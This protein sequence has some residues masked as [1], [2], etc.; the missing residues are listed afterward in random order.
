MRHLL[1]PNPA[2]ALALATAIATALAAGASGAQEAARAPMSGMDHSTM[3]MGDATAPGAMAGYM[4]AMDAMNDAMAG[5]ESTGDADVDF[6]MMMIPHHRSAVDMSRALLLEAK[7]PEVR[8]LAE[9]VIATQEAEIATME[10]MLGRL[11]H[12]VE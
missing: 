4:A 9:A 3:D 12:P 7:D 10:A 6:L 1:T 2:P 5:M 11:G 8:A